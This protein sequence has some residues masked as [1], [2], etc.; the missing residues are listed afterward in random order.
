M[1]MGAGKSA[2]IPPTEVAMAITQRAGS[3]WVNT[4]GFLNCFGKARPIKRADE[5]VELADGRNQDYTDVRELVS[6]FAHEIVLSRPVKRRQQ[7]I[8]TDWLCDHFKVS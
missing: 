4:A 3:H 6:L 1:A 2:G 5:K 8:T 7:A